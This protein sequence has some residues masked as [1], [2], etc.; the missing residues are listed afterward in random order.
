MSTPLFIGNNSVMVIT[1]GPGELSLLAYNS[2]ASLQPTVGGKTTSNTGETRWLISFS[3]TYQ[4]YAFIWQG[5]GQA[6][7]RIGSNLLTGPVGTAWNA[8]S[9]I[10]WNAT[11]VTTTD[12]SSVVPTAVNR[13]GQ[14][15]LWAIPD[16]M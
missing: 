11:S 8:A 7:Y 10:N 12:A 6:V 15:I 1:N 16:K 14:C 9:V 2:N 13:D 3:Y 4:A 5:T